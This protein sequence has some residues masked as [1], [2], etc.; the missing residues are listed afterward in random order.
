MGNG[1]VFLFIMFFLIPHIAF[2]FW[3][4]NDA[5][6]RGKSGCLV[7]L[8]FFF[9]AFPLNLIIWLL[10]RPENQDY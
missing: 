9:V 4:Y 10:I 1:I 3:G 5:E 6:K 7:M 8:L 2:L